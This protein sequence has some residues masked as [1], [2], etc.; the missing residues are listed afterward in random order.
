M[1]NNRLNEYKIGTAIVVV[2]I[3]P[4][5]KVI[6]NTKIIPTAICYH[7]TGNVDASA[8]ANHNYMKNCNKNGSRIASWHF[9]VGH[10]YIYQAQSTNYKCYHAGTTAGNNTSIGV[11][12]CMYSDKEKQIQAYKNAIELG[13]ILMGYH[14]FSINQVKRHKDFSGKHCPAWLIEGKYGYTWNWFK[15]QLSVKPSQP[16]VQPTPQPSVKIDV[17]F[18]ATIIVDELNIRKDADFNSEVVGAVKKGGVYTIVEVKNGL[19]KLAS[20]AGW[21]SVNEKYITKKAKEQ[22]FKPYIARCTT[23]GLNCRKGAGTSYEIETV[24]N[25]GTAITIVEEKMVDETK[26]GKAKSGYWVSLKYMEFV[27]YV[28]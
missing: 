18:L 16:T 7:Q 15:E 8:K 20:G 25:K 23:D 21:I 10:D 14:K 3:L 1:L 12:I 6:P 9:T 2:D 28:E 11:E 24:I 13:K 4:K 22:T 17:P 19:G 27:R 26:W 5:G